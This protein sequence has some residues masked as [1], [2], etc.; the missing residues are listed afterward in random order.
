[1][2]D[3]FPRDLPGAGSQGDPGLDSLLTEEVAD[4]LLDGLPRRA[5]LSPDLRQLRETVDALRAAPSRSELAAESLAL[6]AFRDIRGP[7][8]DDTLVDGRPGPGTRQGAPAGLAHTLQLEIPPDPAGSRP[9]RARHRA[10]PARRPASHP[11]GL[12]R[13]VMRRPRAA[14]TVAALALLV[15]VGVF[16]YAGSLPGPIQNAAHVA[17]GAPPVKTTSASAPSEEANGSARAT[18]APVP[19]AREIRPSAASGPQPPASATPAGP[20]QWCQAYFGN[21]WRP[22]STTWDKT[23]FNKLAKAAPGGAR[24]VLWYCARYLKVGHD[25]GPMTYFFPAG[26]PGGSWAWTPDRGQGKPVGPAGNAPP[27]ASTAQPGSGLSP[28]GG[29]G[30][31]MAGR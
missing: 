17:F 12:P 20:K 24:W 14:G 1:M 8:L 5:A 7:W 21:P 2:R 23:D 18:A 29:P 6:A 19:G 11:G 3:S 31:A 22:G 26:F 27:V 16:A 10:G 9:S 30:P 15:I 4:L 13:P 25:S 28:A